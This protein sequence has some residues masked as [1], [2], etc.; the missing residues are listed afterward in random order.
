MT[1][2]AAVAL[3]GG[4]A[5]TCSATQNESDLFAGASDGVNGADGGGDV[6]VSILDGY[7]LDNNDHQISVTM[8]NDL[9][10]KIHRSVCHQPVLDFAPLLDFRKS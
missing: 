4:V 2:A 5:D 1:A 3:F 6:D 9:S 7:I 10:S 8:Q